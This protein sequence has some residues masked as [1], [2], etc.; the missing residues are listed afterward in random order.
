MKNGSKLLTVLPVVLAALLAAGYLHARADGPYLQDASWP[1]MRG[2]L[3]NTGYGKYMHYQ[4]APERFNEPVRWSTGNGIFSTPVMDGNERIYVGSADHYFYCMDPQTGKVEWKFDALELIDSAAALAADGRVYVPAGAAI[5]ALGLDGDKVWEFDVTNNRPEGLYT[6]GTNYWWEGN[7]VTGPGGNIY[8]GNND[9]FFYRINPAGTMDW[10]HRTGFLIWSVPAFGPDDSMYFAGFDMKLYALDRH[11]GKKKWETNLRNPLVASPA[12]APDGTLYQGGFDGSLYAV[13]SKNGDIKW[14]LR[15]DSHIYS[16]AALDRKGRV[17]VN[18]TDGFLY[19]LDGES[20]EVLWTYYTGDAVRCSP[21][22]GPDPEGEHDYLVYFGGGQGNVYAIE[23]D[24]KRRWSWNTREL[25]GGLD[26]P[27]INAS[28][29]LGKH[30]ITVA[31]ANGDVFYVPYDYYLKDHATGITLDPTEGFEDKG[32]RWHY[33]SSGGVIDKDPVGVSVPACTRTVH[34]GKALVLRLLVRKRGRVSRALIE[35]GSVT[36]RAEPSF[37]YRARMVGDDK[38]VVIT[39][40]ELL[41]PGKEYK[42]RISANYRN[43]DGDTGK[44]DG[45]L[46][47]KVKEPARKSPYMKGKNPGFL[48][49]HMALPQP[50]IVP[51]LDQIGIAILKIPFGLVET[52][53]EAGTFAAWSVQKYGEAAGGEEKGIPDPRSLFYAFGG[54][55]KGEFFTFQARNCSFEETSFPFPLDILRYSGEMDTDGTVKKGASMYAELDPPSIPK[56]LGM[57]SYSTETA[58]SGSESWL[59]ASLAGGQTKGF[60]KAAATTIPTVLGYISNKI[61]E[62]W[63]I[64]NHEGVFVATG[65][66]RMKRL[67]EEE[68]GPPAG[69]RVKSFTYDP[70]KKELTAEVAVKSREGRYTAIGIMLVD[71]QTGKPVPINYNLEMKRMRLENGD[72]KTVLSVPSTDLHSGRL[73]AYIMAD[74]QPLKKI[75]IRTD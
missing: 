63:D 58:A 56:A 28:P 72:K 10:A 2:N 26:Y 20:G 70:F 35:P 5:Y 40:E 18:S 39:P 49:T 16:S 8:A 62:P 57:M 44:V 32:A 13:D 31:N 71:R 61:W 15:T 52:D 23:P 69:L 9:F 37:N 50:P 30:G 11:T 67:P 55:A 36:V 47:L 12:L 51:S 66:F 46:N 75:E 53:P 74:L 48:I 59:K 24:G 7:V 22:L 42:V 60:M 27:N 33:V 38:T 6:F 64:Y 34:P 73:A 1:V 45:V 29:A 17:Y 3:Q 14:K 4:P 25:A 41:T 68:A 21:V 65:T 43:K 19:A 54:E